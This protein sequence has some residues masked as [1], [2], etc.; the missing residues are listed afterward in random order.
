MNKVDGVDPGLMNVRIW[1]LSL[2]PTVDAGED[3][4]GRVVSLCIDGGV[5]G[6]S[7]VPAQNHGNTASSSINVIL[8]GFVLS[9]SEEWDYWPGEVLVS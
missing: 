6:L 3:L 8:V 5:A 7:Q 4:L 2:A 9:F 1:A